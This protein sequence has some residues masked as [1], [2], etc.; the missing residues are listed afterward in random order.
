MPGRPTA[1]GRGLTDVLSGEWSALD[2][3]VPVAGSRSAVV[4]H[5]QDDAHLPAA[6]QRRRLQNLWS[7]LDGAYGSTLVHVQVPFDDE[8]AQSVMQ[9]AGP[10][11]LVVK[12]GLTQQQDLA[13]AIE[14]LTWLGVV[15]HVVGVVSVSGAARSAASAPPM[16]ARQKAKAE[17]AGHAKTDPK[18]DTKTDAKTDGKGAAADADDV[19]L[20]A[21]GADRADA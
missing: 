17:Q 1:A 4:G 19:T 2:T 8:L 9:T 11:L 12:A 13:Y 18:A 14:Q 7:E 15:D 21:Q 10:V 20:T 6:T 3:V 5:G 16:T